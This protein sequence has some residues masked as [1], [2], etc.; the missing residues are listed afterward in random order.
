[1][2]T[3]QRDWTPEQVREEWGR[4]LLSGE[5]RQGREVLTRV[6][7]NGT[8]TDLEHCCL[9]VL[10]VMAVEAGICTTRRDGLTED[11]IYVDSE[12]DSEATEYPLESVND[13]AGIT[14][15]DSRMY[16]IANDDYGYTFEEIAWV[17]DDNQPDRL[18]PRENPHRQRFV[19]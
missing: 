10:Q 8:G 11:V 7:D 4:R 2:A 13:W 17:V 15:E 14:V 19:E 18:T 1:M 3:Q 5:Y 6:M 9:G 16:G 12:T